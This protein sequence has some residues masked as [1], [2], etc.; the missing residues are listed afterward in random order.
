M[1]ND[2]ATLV[3]IY[4]F[5]CVISFS[6]VLGWVTL[7]GTLSLISQLFKKRDDRRVGEMNSMNKAFRELTGESVFVPS[8]TL[9]GIDPIICV[10][11]T[12]DAD[13]LKNPVPPAHM[14][15]CN[16]S[17]LHGTGDHSL[18]IGESDPQV[19]W[20]PFML[21]RNGYLF[22]CVLMTS[23]MVEQALSVVTFSEFPTLNPDNPNSLSS[24]FGK[25]HYYRSNIEVQQPQPSAGSGASQAYGNMPGTSL[26]TAVVPFQLSTGRPSIGNASTSSRSVVGL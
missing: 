9:E 6:L 14:I 7:S 12:P 21:F 19:G 16:A 18:G 20:R 5:A 23:P 15:S 26:P 1:T 4:N 13:P 2:Q 22:V 25:V 3:V 10:D 24:L 11:M 17:D 8:L